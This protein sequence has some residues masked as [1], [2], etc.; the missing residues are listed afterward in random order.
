MINFV[1]HLIYKPMRQARLFLND[2]AISLETFLM[3]GYYRYE[4]KGKKK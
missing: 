3:R 4:L 2:R 1:C